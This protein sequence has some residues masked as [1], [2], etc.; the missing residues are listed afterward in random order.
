M[1]PVGEML[2]ESHRGPNPTATKF[3][4]LVK[5]ISAG[6]LG[7]VFPALQR[8]EAAVAAGQH[9]AGF[10]CYEAAS[11]IDPDL[12]TRPAGAL[13]LLWFGIFAKRT[14]MPLPETEGQKC[15]ETHDWKPSLSAEAY[16]DGVTAIREYIAAGDCYQVN[17]TMPLKFRFSGSPFPFYR[18]LCRSQ[19][20]SYSAYLDLGRYSI[21]SVSPELFFRLDRGVLTVRP[22]K[23]TA[24]RGRWTEEDEL[25][26]RQLRESAKERAENLMIVDLLRNDLGRISRNGT[27]TT[28]SLFDVESFE[29]VHQMT[30][31]V[32]SEIKPGTGFTGLLQALFPCGSVTGAPKK[33]SMEIIAELEDSPRGLYTGCI[34]YMSPGMEEA[35]F[36]VAI[37]SIVIDKHEGAGVLGVGSGITWDSCADA[38]YDECLD[39][40]LFARKVRQEFTLIESVLFEEGQGYFLLDPHLQRIARSAGYFGFAFDRG[41][42]L[43]SLVEEGGLLKGKSK[44]RLELSRDGSYIIEVEQLGN[45]SKPDA[46]HICLAAARVDSSDPFLYHKTSNRGHYLREAGK[47]PDCLDVIFLN[48]RGEITEGANNNIVILRGK[49]TLTPKMECGLLPGTFRQVLL[50]AGEIRE[51]IITFHDLKSADEIY[52]INSVRKWRR[53]YLFRDE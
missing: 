26:A 38:E 29:T 9:A 51:G 20:T 44:V 4:C 13:P 49:E 15:Y 46:G 12:T 8:I 31:T 34:G 17:F 19:H 2:F 33:R 5:E 37:R 30:S 45:G 24:P 39:K 27:V 6:S 42:V 3:S 11:G 50:N 48:E 23:G 53:V 41:K 14:V 10:L 16:P 18:D 36:S 40:G 21:L 1:I 32:T 22:M 7:E 35:L 28:T 47:R 52:L 25:L 43:R